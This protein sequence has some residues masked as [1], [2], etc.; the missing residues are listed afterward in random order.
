MTFTA[1]GAFAW[2]FGFGV[3]PPF[4]ERSVICTA[5]IPNFFFAHQVDL[6]QFS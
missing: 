4:S 6:I 1:G 2:A 5:A 3:Q